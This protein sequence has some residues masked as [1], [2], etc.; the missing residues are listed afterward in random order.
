M[1]GPQCPHLRIEAG[2]PVPAQLGLGA[3][4]LRYAALGFAVMPADRGRK[5]PHRNLAPHGV[6]DATTDQRRIW[7]WWS[8]DPAANVAVA[9]GARSSLLVLDLDHREADG[10]AELRRAMAAWGVSLP[11]VPW[12]STPSGGRHL[13]L[14]LPGGL[15]SVQGALPGV[16]VKADGG[17]VI[18]A[19]SMLLQYPLDRP[20]ERGD[21]EPVPVP[22][23]WADG[24]CP[25]QA[26]PAPAWLLAWAASATGHTAGAGT[27]QAA[28]D[29]PDLAELARTGLPRGQR[30]AGLYRLACS[31][32]R[33][34]GTGPA[35]AA[36]VLG[37]LRAVWAAGDR[38]GMG[39]R[40]V[41]TIAGSARRF[42]EREQAKDAL[43]LAQW[44][45]YLRKVPGAVR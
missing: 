41:L 38:A 28:G 27:Q 16:D 35:G 21:A 24:C 43:A 45:A 5:P 19:P 36:A 18:S 26:P 40:E 44:V 20:G 4:A 17:Y 33:A 8:A 10:S 15:R 1:S 3:A 25:C 14:R 9:T 42:I 2:D 31:R 37:E 7:E 6:L 30:N 32:Y 34:H 22:Y 12:A 11:A 39:W 13:W 23:R 29:S